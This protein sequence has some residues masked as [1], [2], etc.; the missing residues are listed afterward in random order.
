MA[1]HCERYV[2]F[3]F[4]FSPASPGANHQ[5]FFLPVFSPLLHSIH[6]HPTYLFICAASSG[7]AEPRESVVIPKR[8]T[9]SPVLQQQLFR[10]DGISCFFFLDCLF[11]LNTLRNTPD[12]T[13][14][15][16][17]RER[18]LSPTY[19]PP[20]TQIAYSSPHE[21]RDKATIY[22]QPYS[23]ALNISLSPRALYPLPW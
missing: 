6:R 22:P 8:G 23:R 18:R 11:W 2:Q 1:S 14:P 12:L 20:D 21:L 9:E 7:R 10:G 15:D 3:P 17:A 5:P 13:G 19:L 4:L 16:C